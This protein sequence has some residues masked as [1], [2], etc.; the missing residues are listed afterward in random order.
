MQNT[1]SNLSLKLE[2]YRKRVE[3]IENLIAIMYLF[4]TN[5]ELSNDVMEKLDTLEKEL[6]K[7]FL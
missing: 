5:E 6:E 3:D 7:E 2:Q 4:P 1:S